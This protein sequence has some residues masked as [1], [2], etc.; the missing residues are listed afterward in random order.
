MLVK[1]HNKSLADAKQIFF[2]SRKMKCKD[3]EK[4][5]SSELLKRIEE[6]FNNW[7]FQFQQKVNSSLHKSLRESLSRLEDTIRENKKNKD[8]F[9]QF[10]KDLNEKHLKE[11]KELQE[12]VH[13]EMKKL[14]T[15]HSITVKKLTEKI[16]LLEENQASKAEIKEL[17]EHLSAEIGKH[18]EKTFICKESLAVLQ[19]HQ[20]KLK[21]SD[22]IT[23]QMKMQSIER[24]KHL[25]A[26]KIKV[27]DSKDRFNEFRLSV[28]K[29]KSSYTEEEVEKLIKTLNE[30]NKKVASQ[31]NVIKNQ[32]ATI[33][34]KN[35]EIQNL[36]KEKEIKSS[37]C[38][39]F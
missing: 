29:D 15:E 27:A 24:G 23:K 34:E 32:K 25:E 36:N 21:D 28:E 30:S 9:E 35:H 20:E 6:R 12:K 2:S 7:K 33:E 39:I 31:N 4:K 37:S 11:I 3:L 1:I 13:A 5:Y 17:K 19:E 14:Q 22:I 38:K 16:K 8:D 18:H 10:S 26:M